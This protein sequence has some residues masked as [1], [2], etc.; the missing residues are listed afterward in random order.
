MGRVAAAVA[1]AEPGDWIVGRGWHQEKWDQPPSPNVE[2]YPT[3]ELLS[4]AAPENPV[5]LGHASGHAS[6][7]NA[8]ALELAGIDASTPD[9]P[10]G[11]ILRGRRGAPTGVL[12]ETADGPAWA[13]YDAAQSGLSP[14]DRAAQAR[15]ALEL[16][17]RDCLAKGV[18][19]FQ[20]A[21]TG[22]AT[23]DLMRSMAE[24]GEL[25]VRLWVMLSESNDALEERAADYRV[26]GAADDHLTVRAIKRLIDGALGAH[27]AWLL[28]PYSDLPESSGLTRTHSGVGSS[29][30]GTSS[31]CSGANL[32][33]SRFFSLFAPARIRR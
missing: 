28:E 27:G 26:I 31:N 14:E 17:D 20:D 11:T 6:I 25:G 30:S 24:A 2:G 29:G 16:A 21:G 12:R 9:P 33:V 23:I 22:Y 10:G 7:A 15:R 32:P 18:T 1:E 13:A 4:A 5:L 19:S 3:H 8:R